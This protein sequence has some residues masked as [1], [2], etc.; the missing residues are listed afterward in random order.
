MKLNGVLEQPRGETPTLN[1]MAIH[2]QRH[3]NISK[4][5]TLLVDVDIAPPQGGLDHM[6][7]KCFA[8][9]IELQQEG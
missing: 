8:S 4:Q 2:G 7:H 5:R 1:V 3:T 6:T 9:R